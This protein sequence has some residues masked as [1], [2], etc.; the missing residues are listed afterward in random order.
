MTRL[1]GAFVF[2]G[3]LLTAGMA[4]AQDLANQ[5]VGVWQFGPSTRQ[6]DGGEKKDHPISGT[7]IFTKGGHF[8]VMQHPTERKAAT[9]DAELAALYRTSFFG[10]GTYKVE[11]DQV[12]LKYEVCGNPTWIGQERRPN[13]KAADKNMTWTTPQLKDPEGKT[14]VDTY[15]ITRLE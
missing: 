15:T 2:L 8:A 11:G 13:F 12:V 1:M 10:S 7:V 9:N 4:S 6:Y 5:L 14:F 3:L